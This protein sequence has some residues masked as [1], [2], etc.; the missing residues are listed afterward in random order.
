MIIKN[1]EAIIIPMCCEAIKDW[2]GSFLF[3]FLFS[4][5]SYSLP[6]F[7]SQLPCLCKLICMAYHGQGQ[8]ATEVADLVQGRHEKWHIYSDRAFTWSKPSFRASY[9]K[10]VPAGKSLRASDCELPPAELKL[11]TF[12]ISSTMSVSD[13]CVRWILIYICFPQACIVL[14]KEKFK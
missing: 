13:S 9:W 11:H 5:S 2:S 4:C 6:C 8:S 1:S 10:T 12:P 3:V 14:V 7:F